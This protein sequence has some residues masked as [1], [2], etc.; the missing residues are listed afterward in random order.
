[1]HSTVPLTS[2]KKTILPFV[3]FR[4]RTKV[5]G[6]EAGQATLSEMFP[7]HVRAKEKESVG[8]I[9]DYILEPNRRSNYNVKAKSLLI[10]D[11]DCETLSAKHYEDTIKKID[12]A[13]SRLR[14]QD[15]EH[16][17]YSSFSNARV[18]ENPPE[19]YVGYRLAIP[20]ATP[21]V[22]PR[23]DKDYK[24]VATYFVDYFSLPGNALAVSQPWYLPS[25]PIDGPEPIYRY[26]PGSL[27]LD[28]PRVPIAAARPRV[29]VPR[30]PVDVPYEP[31]DVDQLRTKLVTQAGKTLLPALRCVLQGRAPA[32]NEFKSRHDDIVRPITILIARV[33]KPG[34]EPEELC[35]VMRP[36]CEAMD[37]RFPRGGNFGWYEECVRALKGAVTKIE[38]WR[39]EEEQELAEFQRQPSTPVSDGAS[40]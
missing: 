24:S 30:A 19:L 15:V 26:H 4:T 9:G 21:L 35:E 12:E 38:E 31:V 13:C 10:L 28:W 36:W 17:L 1:M 37:Q 34:Q 7:P 33:A 3:Q 27:A 25:A 5:S 32:L 2:T 14:E 39:L 18:K 23:L 16:L 29:V 6:G 22:T 11:V 8:L 40:D 20:F